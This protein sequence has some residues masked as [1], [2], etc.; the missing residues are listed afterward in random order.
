MK[1]NQTVAS[2][3]VEGGGGDRVSVQ[4]YVVKV[5]ELQQLLPSRNRV[6]VS[7]GVFCPTQGLTPGRQNNTVLSIMTKGLASVQLS[8][9]R[10]SRYGKVQFFSINHFFTIWHS[11]AQLKLSPLS[12]LSTLNILILTNGPLISLRFNGLND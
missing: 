5:V 6:G 12:S 7:V 8:D 2:L 4:A 9:L 3:M 1:K 10:S 11:W